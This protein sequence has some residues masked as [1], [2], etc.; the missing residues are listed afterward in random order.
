MVVAVGRQHIEG[1]SP[2][3]FFQRL[4]ARQDMFDGQKE[5]AVIVTGLLPVIQVR[6]GAEGLYMMFVLP[7]R[8]KR[9]V[10]KWARPSS[11]SS[12]LGDMAIPA[13]LSIR[14]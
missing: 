1:H 14:E 10:M 3:G 2:K 5:L 12:R 9:R 11:S 7:S 13:A 8:S 4:V 6:Y